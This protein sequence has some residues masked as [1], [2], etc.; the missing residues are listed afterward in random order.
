MIAPTLPT[1]PEV[2]ALAVKTGWYEG[3]DTSSPP[4]D[5][6]PARLA[7]VHAELSEALEE[8]RQTGLPPR[9]KIT[10]TVT[11]LADAVLRI[12]D[13]CGAL[14]LPI[15]EAIAQKHAFNA[16]R[17]HRHGGKVV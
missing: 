8:Y 9:G 1:P 17:S 12:F 14:G 16:S 5:W 6:F 3:V 13:M 11:E 10:P 7:L 2:H 4:S 15:V